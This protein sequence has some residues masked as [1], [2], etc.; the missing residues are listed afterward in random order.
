MRHRIYQMQQ[1]GMSDDAIVST[2]VREEGIVAL[3]APPAHG[4]GPIVTWVM[5]GVAL[6]LGFFVY[7]SWL[8]RN[9]KEPEPLTEVDQ[10]TLD[11]FRAQI[12]SELEDAPESQKKRK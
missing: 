10:V 12:D 9:R 2:I 6:V 5:P 7:S 8:R 4:V 3:A 1:T 11:R